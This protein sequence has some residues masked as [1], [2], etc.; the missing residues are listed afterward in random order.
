MVKILKIYSLGNFH[1]YEKV[2]LAI[3]I[4]Y[5][6]SPEL[7]YLKTGSLYLLTIFAKFTHPLLLLL[8]QLQIRFCLFF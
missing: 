4:M 3:V 5:I 7:I 2:L 1:I 6:I 8:W